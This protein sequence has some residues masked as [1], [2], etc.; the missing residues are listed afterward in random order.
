MA[1]YKAWIMLFLAITLEITGTALMKHF[2]IQN[3]IIGYVS[4]MIFMGF[5]YFALSKAVI[6]IPIST[7]YAVW[8]GIGLVGT[9][10][11]A[12]LIFHE[13]MP[14]TKIFAF[15]IILTGLTMIKL[16]TINTATSTKAGDDY[17]E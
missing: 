16:G 3:W 9:A 4:M 6:K 8:E 2:S 15:A 14:S 10:F 11:I 5:S 1:K 7:A 12:W 13:A 17:H